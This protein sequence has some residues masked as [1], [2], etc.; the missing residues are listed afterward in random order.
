MRNDFSL[1]RTYQDS[2]N[3]DTSQRVGNLEGKAISNIREGG[4]IGLGALAAYQ[5]GFGIIPS[6][7]LTVGNNRTF[8][9]KIDLPSNKE[10]KGQ[11]ETAEADLGGIIYQGQKQETAKE[12]RIKIALLLGLVSNDNAEFYT[13]LGVARNHKTL[14]QDGFERQYTN[15]V[16]TEE[17]SIERL[18]A[19]YNKLY[20]SLDVGGIF[21]SNNLGVILNLGY[22]QKPG[23]LKDKLSASGGLTFYPG[24]R[25][26]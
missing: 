17:N 9:I 8:G 14:R 4:Y 13:G 23:S 21:R 10:T 11:L 26:K 12:N 15:G 3:T 2:I 22:T 24:S 5:N 16:L 25:R 7:L 6:L 20:P 19:D 1:F 18:L